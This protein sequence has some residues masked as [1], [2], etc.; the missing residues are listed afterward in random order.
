MN[1]IS[2]APGQI[3]TL[4]L[5]GLKT[6]LPLGQT[7]TASTIPS[8]F[9]LSGISITINQEE[10]GSNV[11]A[12][13]PLLAISQVNNCASS[14]PTPGCANNVT[15]ITVQIPFELSL[16]AGTLWGISENNGAD[17]SG[18]FDL[19]PVADN[20]HAVTTCDRGA[21]VANCQAVVTHANG[22][23]ISANSPAKASE[24]LVIYA[25]GLGTTTPAVL[26]GTA[27]PIPAAVVTSPVNIQYD[28]RP[29]AAPSRP[30]TGVPLPAPLF[31]GLTPGQVGLYQINVRLPGS[32]PL[33]P[34]CDQTPPTTGGS[35]DIVQSNLTIDIGSVNSFD[36]AA[37][38][39]LTQQ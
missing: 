26:T 6:I 13:V 30:Y 21:A 22:T 27:S 38:C 37:I 29:N 34:P 3:V 12:P 35:T 31:V 24:E 18:P 19:N 32:F 9:T 36:G 8:P 23:V 2:V 4:Q 39:V 17:N 7:I 1:R 16:T 15:Y 33:L 5:T 25:L 11:I 28:F 10:K 20:I 14:A